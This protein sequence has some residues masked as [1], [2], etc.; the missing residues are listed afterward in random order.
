[1]LFNTSIILF[2]IFYDSRIL[3]NPNFSIFLNTR[4]FQ[5]SNQ[6]SIILY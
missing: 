5:T 4:S 2:Y 1:M 6:N 3:N